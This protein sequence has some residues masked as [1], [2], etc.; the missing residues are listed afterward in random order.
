MKI[1]KEGEKDNVL[2]SIL[3]PLDIGDYNNKKI[4]KILK[5]LQKTRKE[6]G[7][8]GLAAN[9]C[10]IKE[11]VFVIGA[12][13]YDFF[14][15]VI[16][17]VIHESLSSSLFIGADEGCLSFCGKNQRIFPLQETSQS[18]VSNDE[19]LILTILR[20]EWIIASFYDEISGKYYDKV[21]LTGLLSRVFQH[22]TDHLNGIL[23]TDR[24]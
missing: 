2:R 17:P 7:G 5:N 24:I 11:R 21:K 23:F 12:D 10:G 22:E 20:H 3:P 19:D 9:Q 1:Y 8:I 4:C 14:L 18:D 16:N 6:Y 15:N 13:R